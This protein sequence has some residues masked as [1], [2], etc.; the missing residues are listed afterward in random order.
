MDNSVR[1][2]SSE[3][4]DSQSSLPT[5]KPAR[6][7]GAYSKPKQVLG[8]LIFGVVLIICLIV[9]F[10]GGGDKKTGSSTNAANTT[11]ASQAITQPDTLST[12][13]KIATWNTKYGYIFQTLGNDFNQMSKDADNSN[14]VLVSNDC[15]QINTDVTTA[16]NFS[17]IP[18]AQTASDFSSALTYYQEGSQQCVT[19]ISNNDANG[20]VQAA[21][22]ISRGTDKINATNTDIVNIIKAGN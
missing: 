5:P 12:A 15:Q 22:I 3:P 9:A 11:P 2:T 19:A 18:D 7:T 16:Q 21:Q 1:P 17:A 8:G 10:G 6:Q 14:P 13:S 20:I 4:Q